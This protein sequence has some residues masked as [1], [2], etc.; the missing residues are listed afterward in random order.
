[1]Q[2]GHEL[3]AGEGCGLH[4]GCHPAGEVGFEGALVGVAA[5]VGFAGDFAH[6][7][8]VGE[9]ELEA[10]DDVFYAGSPGV[11]LASLGC[12]LVKIK[13]EKRLHVQNDTCW[14]PRVA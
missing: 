2:F 6:D 1:M 14:L 11:G 10:F 5:A 12:E 3:V 7:V 4:G 8:V 9:E 13:K